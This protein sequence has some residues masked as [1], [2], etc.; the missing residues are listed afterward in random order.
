[1]DYIQDQTFSHIGGEDNR[2]PKG[3]FENCT[4]ANCDFYEADLANNQFAECT[5]TGCNLSLAKLFGTAFRDVAF[6]DCK[7]LGLHFEQCNVFNLSFRFERCA[8]NHSSFYQLKIKKIRFLQC[9]LQEADFTE[10]DLTEALFDNCDLAGATFD[11]TML[12]KADLRT[13][14]HY[15]INPEAN[16]IRKAKFSLSGLP[17][18]LMAYDIE[19]D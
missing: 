8:L 18:L 13:S 19:I 4:F 16:R 1:M 5:F 2:L 3:V 9:Q 14:F 7:M 11:Q 6:T 12:H 17:G 15:I 10:T